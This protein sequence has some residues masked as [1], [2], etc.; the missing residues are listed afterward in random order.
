MTKEPN[1]VGTREV[2]EN[3]DKRNISRGNKELREEQG[4]DTGAKPGEKVERQD[5]SH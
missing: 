3:P 1:K 2:V 4:T 5:Q